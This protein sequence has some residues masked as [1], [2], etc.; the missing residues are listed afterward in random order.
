MPNIPNLLL[1]LAVDSL[2]QQDMW[3]VNKFFDE[4]IFPLVDENRFKIGI[5]ST[6][7][8]RYIINYYTFFACGFM[9]IGFGRFL[10]MIFCLTKATTLY[11]V[12]FVLSSENFLLSVSISS[13]P[14]WKG[15]YC[16]FITAYGL[17]SFCIFPVI[18][19][20]PQIK[21]GVSFYKS[22]WKIEFCWP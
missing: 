16:F 2:R 12:S 4:S 22:N 10:K 20:C 19:W 8:Q 18:T 5:I 6:S 17:S 13:I 21:C 1:A 15:M 14:S 3:K 7:Q 9:M 11:K